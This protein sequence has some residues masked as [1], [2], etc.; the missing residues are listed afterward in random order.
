MGDTQVT[1][2]GVYPPNDPRPY[3]QSVGTDESQRPGPGAS[4]NKLENVINFFGFGL[5]EWVLIGALLLV[6]F[7]LGRDVET[8]REST[9]QTTMLRNHVDHL[10]NQLE[11]DTMLYGKLGVNPETNLARLIS[12]TACKQ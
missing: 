12:Q 4:A 8:R 1:E 6:A 3:S 11:V 9:Y 2:T 10:S 7:V 5:K